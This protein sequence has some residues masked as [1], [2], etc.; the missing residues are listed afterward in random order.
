MD[1]DLLALVL[2]VVSTATAAEI[3]R[4]GSL[5]R[6]AQAELNGVLAGLRK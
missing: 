4:G 2:L 6:M 1:S 5:S 3:R